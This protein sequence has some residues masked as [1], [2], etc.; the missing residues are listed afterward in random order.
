MATIAVPGEKINLL[1]SGSFTTF[2]RGIKMISKPG[3]EFNFS[4]EFK[5]ARTMIGRSGSR[6]FIATKETTGRGE[7]LTREVY[8]VWG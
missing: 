3:H 1:T 5:K 7:N 6:L 2:K 8:Q 4:F